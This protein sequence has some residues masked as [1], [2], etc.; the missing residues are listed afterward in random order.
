[1]IAVDITTPPPAR[2]DDERT[3]VACQWAVRRLQRAQLAEARRI[4][5]AVA[6]A[7][8]V[9]L[10]QLQAAGREREVSEARQVAMHAMRVRLLWPLALRNAPFPFEQ[11]GA[12]LG[13]RDH[14]TVM[15]GV[16]A[17]AARLDGAAEDAGCLRY[18]VHAIHATLD[19]TYEDDA[20]RRGHAA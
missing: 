19:A 1:M 17:I 8:G 4:R 10:A 14:S 7:Y 11:I 18:M 2:A 9:P 3:R 16:A 12:L 15:H 6:D 13:E 5:Q 20:D